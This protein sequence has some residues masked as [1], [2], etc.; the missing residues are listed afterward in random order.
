MEKKLPIIEAASELAA[1]LSRTS[2]KKQRNIFPT[3]F[4]DVLGRQW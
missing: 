2:R 1:K 3:T 4:R